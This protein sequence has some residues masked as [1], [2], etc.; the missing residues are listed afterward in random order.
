MGPQQQSSPPLVVAVATAT[1][2]LVDELLAGAVV[3][4]EAAASFRVVAQQAVVLQVVVGD[5][6]G[7]QNDG[8]QPAPLGHQHVVGFGVVVVNG[9]PGLDLGADAQQSLGGGFAPLE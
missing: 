5:G 4:L 7:A 3:Q 6:K 2:P 9:V 8:R 1:A